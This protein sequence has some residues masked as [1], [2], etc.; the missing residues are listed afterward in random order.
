MFRGKE[1]VKLIYYNELDKPRFRFVPLDDNPI[2]SPDA[3]ENS[4]GAISLED[5]SAELDKTATQLFAL[6]QEYSIA[7]AVAREYGKAKIQVTIDKATAIARAYC[8]GID[9]YDE[10]SFEWAEYTYGK[11]NSL[12]KFLLTQLGLDQLLADAMKVVT[13]AYKERS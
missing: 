1:Y 11:L 13:S 9:Q 3:K 5:L 2:F 7:A 10:D 6:A 8:I 4:G 12:D